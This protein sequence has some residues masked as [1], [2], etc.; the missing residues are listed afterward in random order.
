[1]RNLHIGIGSTSTLHTAGVD[2]TLQ[3]FLTKD[4]KEGGDGTLGNL[5]LTSRWVYLRLLLSCVSSDFGIKAKLQ[6][7]QDGKSELLGAWRKVTQDAKLGLRCLIELHLNG[8]WVLSPCHIE[9]AEQFADSPAKI[10]SIKS[11]ISHHIEYLLW[12]SGKSCPGNR[13]EFA[14]QRIVSSLVLSGNE[15]IHERQEPCWGTSSLIS[16]TS[17]GLLLLETVLQHP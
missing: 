7:V 8:W 3:M 12:E 1:M 4:V 15:S 14:E 10:F 16:R 11:P 13:A 2:D 17:G 5:G 6:S 9:K